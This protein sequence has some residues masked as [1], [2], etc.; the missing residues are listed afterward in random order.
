M[1]EMMSVKKKKGFLNVKILNQEHLC[2]VSHAEDK[3]LLTVVTLA[4]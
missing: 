1:K 3:W 4:L 2:A